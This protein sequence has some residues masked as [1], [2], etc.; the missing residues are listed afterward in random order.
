M[1]KLKFVKV[2]LSIVIILMIIYSLY[3]Y[4]CKNNDFVNWLNTLISTLISV[5]LALIIAMYIFYY[6]TNLIEKETKEKYLPLI[7]GSL[8]SIWKNLADLSEAVKIRFKNGEE[9]NLYTYIIQDIIF[10][11]AIISNVFNTLQTEF[12]LS[13][14]NYINYNNRVIEMI[15]NM[16]P[17][18]FKNPDSYKNKFKEL[19]FNNKRSRKSIKKAIESSSKYFKFNK[20]DNEIKNIMKK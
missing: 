10:E 17:L 20:L 19:Q 18:C 4:I 1:K 9:I 6:Q 8:I 13:M 5:S 16:D 3:I 2:I 7:E 14:R 11:Q 12:L 15:I